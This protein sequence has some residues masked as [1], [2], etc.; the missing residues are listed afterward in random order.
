MIATIAFGFWSGLL[1]FVENIDGL[2]H[3]A[4]VEQGG[5]FAIEH[6]ETYRCDENGANCVLV[7]EKTEFSEIEGLALEEQSIEYRDGSEEIM[8]IKMPGIPKYSH[9]T[10]KRPTGFDWKTWRFM[11]ERQ[12]AI[13]KVEKE[14]EE[15]LKEVQAEE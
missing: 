10:M 2:E 14:Y 8:T 11:F 3:A 12:A 4:G 7:D 15:K 9:I 6:Q 13:E 1:E 5:A